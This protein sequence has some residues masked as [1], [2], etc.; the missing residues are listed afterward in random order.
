MMFM[1]KKRGEERSKT[2]PP[3]R[4]QKKKEKKRKSTEPG[5]NY[6]NTRVTRVCTVFP[7]GGRKS[8]G[9]MK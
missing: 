3:T 9:K 5:S 7:T 8:A 4:K 6:T 1:K 2:L